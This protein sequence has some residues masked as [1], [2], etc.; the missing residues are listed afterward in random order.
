[1]KVCLCVSAFS[2]ACHLLLP[3]SEQYV[4]VNNMCA[5]AATP[6]RCSPYE[7]PIIIVV[8]DACLAQKLYS[9]LYLNYMFEC[10]ECARMPLSKGN[11]KYVCLRAEYIPVRGGDAGCNT[12]CFYERLP[13]FFFLVFACAIRGSVREF[14]FLSRGRHSWT[15]DRL[16][17]QIYA[18]FVSTRN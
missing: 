10:P 13:R 12:F 14:V 2:T 4:L 11:T 9:L 16:R 18:P 3:A 17:L 6:F 7:F 1:M 5:C 15:T 8:D